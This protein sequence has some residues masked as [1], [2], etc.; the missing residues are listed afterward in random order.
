MH[1]LWDPNPSCPLI[2]ECSAK[3]FHSFLFFL[4]SGLYSNAP[5][6]EF[7][8]DHTVD[9]SMSPPAPSLQIS[10]AIHSP[11]LVFPH[12]WLFPRQPALQLDTTL[13]QMLQH[14]GP[15]WVFSG[16]RLNR[17]CAGL[18]LMTFMKTGCMKFKTRR[19]WVHISLAQSS[20]CLCWLGLFEP[21]H[22]EWGW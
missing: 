21:R 18:W 1:P 11:C 15:Q 13:L 10:P 20:H 4:H 8:P 14:M 16:W 12:L 7:F 3:T 17:S 22:K 5:S 19:N 6:S 2:L 9:H